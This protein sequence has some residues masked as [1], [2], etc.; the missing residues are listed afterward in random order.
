MSYWPPIQEETK[1]QGKM[2]DMKMRKSSLWLLAGKTVNSFL[3]D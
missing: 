2:T 1:K 3:G